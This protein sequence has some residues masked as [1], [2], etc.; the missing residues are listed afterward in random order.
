MSSTAARSWV[1]VLGL[2]ALAV[3]FL[4]LP[5]APHIFARL[6]CTSCSSSDP[7]LSL[8][9][10]GYFAVLVAAAL[11]FPGFPGRL[12]ARGGLTW[13]LLLAL[14]LTYVKWPAWCAA[15]LIGHAC[16]ILMWT[17]WVAVP[18]AARRPRPATLGQRLVLTVFAPV[19]VIALFSSLNLT[20]MAYRLK[21][22]NLAAT[23]LQPGDA[24]PAFNTQTHGGR[25]IA[26]TDAAQSA[27]IVI[28]FVSP[29]C[30]HCQEQMPVLDAVATELA[31]GSYRFINVSRA[32]P[33][34][35]L[36][37]APATEWVEDKEG[38][39]RELFQVAG[40][41][42]M[43]VLGSDGKITLVIPGVPEQLKAFLLTSL[44]RPKSAGQQ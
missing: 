32:L 30:P 12:A 24:V 36:Q 40:Y 37:R 25:S 42:T 35:L 10:A 18:P 2:V 9:G 15:C 20:F 34:E 28:N 33:A 17:L 43:F 31:P 19:S 5:E 44:T 41:P 8:V 4:N 16:N 11:L 14:A 23:S 38:K 6:G 13:A 27:G 22:H 7:Y 26:S 3:L 21:E 1:P 39:L 29:D